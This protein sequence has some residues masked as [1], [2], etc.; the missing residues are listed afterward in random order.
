MLQSASVEIVNYNSEDQLSVMNG[1][2]A[3]TYGNGVLT[4]TG[5]ASVEEFQAAI[6]NIVYSNTVDE[7]LSDVK[8]ITINVTDSPVF[9]TDSPTNN[10]LMIANSSTS[11]MIEIM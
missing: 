3:S 11:N 8:M 9:N 2:L 1:T 5:P 6:N 7:P 4:I 10:P